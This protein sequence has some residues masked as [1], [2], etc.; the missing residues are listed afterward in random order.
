MTVL[1][2]LCKLAIRFAFVTILLLT[3]LVNRPVRC[4]ED[5]GNELYS[6]CTRERAADQLGCVSYLMGF[7]VGVHSEAFAA[8]EDHPVKICLPGTLT[9]AQARLIFLKRARTHPGD[10]SWPAGIG[11]RQ[12]FQ[13]AFPCPVRSR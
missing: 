2:T 12:A 13:D 10:L 1:M 9:A 8:N 5:S 7:I 6:M 11:V 3:I 4:E